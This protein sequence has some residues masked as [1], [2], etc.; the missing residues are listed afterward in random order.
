MINL[1]AQKVGPDFKEAAQSLGSPRR[2]TD[3]GRANLDLRDRL[4]LISVESLVLR[5]SCK[6]N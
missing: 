3:H 6:A 1:G 2:I 5:V 4:V